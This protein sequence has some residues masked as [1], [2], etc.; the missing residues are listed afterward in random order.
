MD[1]HVTVLTTVTL[2]IGYAMARAGVAKNAL[3][4][5]RGSRVCPSCGKHIRAR[6]CRTCAG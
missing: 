2:A 5:R 1:P 6:V 3:E 4:W